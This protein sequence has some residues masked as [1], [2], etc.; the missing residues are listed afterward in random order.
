MA[1][2]I[3][4]P[5][6]TVE[7]LRVKPPSVAGMF[8]PADPGVLR[9]QVRGFLKAA[10]PYRDDAPKAVIAPHAGYRY[11]GPVAGS[12][13]APLI[14]LAGK[15][16]RVVL[17]GPSHRV[18]FRGV[19]V[20]SADAF[21]TP[22]GA[23]P[24]DAQGLEVARR[25]PFVGQLDDAFAEEHSLEVHLP[26]LIEALGE[27]HLVPLLIG[28][29]EPRDVAQ[30]IEALWGGPETLIVISSDLSHFHD[31]DTAKRRDEATSRAI[32]A[33]DHAAIGYGDAC[34]RNAVN[35]LLYL[36][37]ERGL[38]I[39]TVDLRN[40]GD[41]AGGRDRVVGYGAYLVAEQGVERLP[42]ADRRILLGIAANSI[43]HGIEHGRPKP[44]DPEN[45]SEGLRETRASFVTLKLD[46]QLRGCIGTLD[47]SRSL[48]EDVAYNAHAAAFADKRFSPVTRD[49]ADRL[50]IG[51]SVLSP[52]TPLAVRSEDDLLAKLRPGVD[53]LLLEEGN[54]RGTFLPSVWDTLP[55]PQDFVRQLK[56]K[57]GFSADYWSDGISVKRYTTESFS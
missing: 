40:S 23:V 10:E 34:G 49:E 35:G 16:K 37:K 17:L 19:A 22:L 46:G 9:D 50:E 2:Q 21:N 30:L 57:A 55:A 12:A 44:V 38:A 47:A 5:A 31:Y 14:P 32:E 27:F 52:P 51:I 41:T 8:Y 1:M 4:G 20:N 39:R 13:Y 33:L 48:V 3:R 7:L 36:G 42:Y 29:A 6:G 56:L 25:F 43:R 26:F 45:Y 18:P 28:D 11:S 15:I 53:G 54:R 24:V